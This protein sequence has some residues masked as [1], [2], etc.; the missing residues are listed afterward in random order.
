MGL[1]RLAI[2]GLG[3]LGGSIGLAIKERLK[4]CTVVG[5]AHRPETLKAAMDL[6]AI[7]I[8][9]DTPGKAVEQADLIVICTPVRLIAPMITEISSSLKH[10][11]VVTDVGS[12]KR[13]IV[14]EAARV[15][16][17]QFVGSHPMAGSEKRGVEF[18]RSDL[19]QNALCIVTPTEENPPG[20]ERVEGFW[21]LLGMHTVRM[22]A[23]AHDQDV[24]DVSHLP[25]LLAAAIVSMQHE[26]AL[27]VAG[28][29]FLDMTRI[30]AG[31]GGLWRDILIDNRKAVQHSLNRLKRVLTGIETMLESEDAEGV[32]K[33]LEDAAAK[34]ETI[35]RSNRAK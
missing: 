28:R 17:R 7:D 14:Q 26:Q 3:L 33:W 13:S 2:L 18:A 11:S 35:G 6:G 20:I 32:K 19:F 10:D 12:T 4:S 9:G 15:I 21:R 5:Y 25:H 8:G 1:D 23:S 22:N 29:G 31:D 30:A 24:S 16:P 34:R 27:S